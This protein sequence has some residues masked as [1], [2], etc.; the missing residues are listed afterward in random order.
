MLNNILRHEANAGYTVED[1][2]RCVRAWL[3]L[4]SGRVVDATGSSTLAHPTTFPR[5]PGTRLSKFNGSEVR[6]LAHLTQLVEAC[7]EAWMKFEFDG[8]KEMIVLK[9]GKVAGAT[10]EVCSQN[11]IPAAKCGGGDG[12]A[13]TPIP[14]AAAV[15]G[16]AES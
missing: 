7:T 11:M 9:T 12:A 2:Y 8:M 15:T 10:L 5:P 13:T 16:A 14:A 1:M 3:L 6:S 4:L